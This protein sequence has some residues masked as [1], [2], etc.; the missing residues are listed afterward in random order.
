MANFTSLVLLPG[1]DGTGIFFEPLLQ[2]LPPWVRP[3]VVEYP[4]TGN[5]D[6]GELLAVIRRA[7][8]GMSEYHV[9]GWS[10]SGPLALMLAAAEPDRV[11]GV[12]LAA[13]FVTPPYTWLPWTRWAL[14]APVVWSWRVMR[15]LPLWLF[16]P[17]TDSLRRAKAQT[18]NRIPARVLACRLQALAGVDAREALRGCSAPI[19]QLASS[20]DLIVPRRNAEEIRFERSSVQTEIIPGRH[21][22]LYTHPSAAAQV[23]AEFIAGLPPRTPAAWEDS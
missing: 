5:N 12:M 17:R 15:R 16:Q 11:C 8:Q 20:H 18:W 1:L 13:T 10:F 22:A 23:I 6:Y 9:L 3:V 2:A 21:L 19:L 14:V 7:T 4:T